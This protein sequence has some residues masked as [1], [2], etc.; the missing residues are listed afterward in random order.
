MRILRLVSLGF[1]LSGPA[2]LA[3]AQ[4]P[5]PK[6][7][8]IAG[9]STAAFNG[10]TGPVGW[11]VVLQE[12]FDPAKVQVVNESRGGRSSR[13]F[14]SEG[15]WQAALDQARP[16]DV[17]LIQFGHN[18]GGPVNDTFRARGSIP[19]LGSETQEI[20]NLITKKHEIVRTF[21]W[22][23][24]LFVEQSKAKG[25]IPIV[26]SPT[27]RN[28][29]TNGTVEH[30]LGQYRNWSREVAAKENVQYVDLSGLVAAAYERQGQKAT[31]AFF[32]KDHTHTNQAGAE[33]NARWVVSGLK[34]LAND[35]LDGSF[36]AAP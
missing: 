4:S 13:T 35:P 28:I 15:L 5:L 32:P 12:Y 26:V 8:I 14:Y 2:S 16:G 9:D 21:G 18:D 1:L 30:D 11:G 6:R 34:G 33:F 17:V 36:S 10:A 20:D 23:L 27:I 24:E 19:G 25:A 31:A 3:S 22:Y 7:L 29:W